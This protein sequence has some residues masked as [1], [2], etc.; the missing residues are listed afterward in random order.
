MHI[1]RSVIVGRDEELAQLAHLLAEARAGRGGAAFLTGEPGIGK[2]R[3][4]VEAADL[5]ATTDMRMLRGRASD[6]G[7]AVPFRPLSEALMSLL[8]GASPPPVEDLGPYRPVLG[9]LVPDWS[10]PGD[11]TDGGSLVVLAEAI[12]RL[13]AILGRGRGCLLVLEDLHDADHETLAVVEYVVDNL[14][15]LPAVLLATLRNGPSGALQL[16]QSAGQRRAGSILELERLTLP[17]VRD[18]IASC[19]EST[20][21][22]VPAPVAEQLW[23]DSGGSPF[24]AEELLHGLVS[25]G[26][27]VP[28]AD[29]WRVTGRIRTEV[30]ASLVRTITDRA[31]RLG[32]QGRQ[33]LSV[34]AVLGHR[35]PLSVVHKVTG[36]SYDALLGQLHAAVAARLVTADEP[37]PDWYAFQ[38]PLTGEALLTRLTPAEQAELSA[39]A[40]DVV[41]TIHPGL[42]GEWCQLVAALRLRAGDR[43]SAARLFADAGRRALAD[44]APGS[45]VTL[46]ERAEQLLGNHE[47]NPLRADVVEALLYAMAEGGEFERAFR[48]ADTLDALG[49]AGLAAPR[50]AALHLRLAWVA[51]SAGRWADGLTQV[52]VA[53][54]LLGEDAADEDTAPLDAVDADLALQAPGARRKQ[55]AEL[56][57]RRAV[58][59]AE[60][61]SLPTVAC[62]AWLVIGAVARERNVAEST[63]CYEKVREIAEEHRLPMW[64]VHG[65]FRAA[66]NAWLAESDTEGLHHAGREARRVG[67]LTLGQNVDATTALHL[68]LCGDFVA[69]VPV[70]DECLA[71][72][73][74]MHLELVGRHL[75]MSRATLAAH[76][77]RRREMEAALLDF[78]RLDGERSQEQPMALGMARA[79]CA[80]LEENRDRARDDI[81]DAL[82]SDDVNPTTFS[83]FGR[84]GLGLLLGVLEGDADWSRYDEFRATAQGAMRWN[85]QFVE[86][87][88]AVLLGRSG[89]TA[90]AEAAVVAAQ[91]SAAPYAMA[92]HLGLRLVAEAAV[93]DGW[94]DPASWLRSAEEYFHNGQVPAV[95]SACRS[96]LRQLGVS[97]QQRRTGTERVPRPLR[98]LGV[99]IREF[100][101]L[102]L[103]IERLDT[104]TI[105]ERL[106]ISPR[107]VEKHVASL[108]IRTDT[109]DRAALARHAGMLLADGNRRVRESG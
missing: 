29:G 49:N 58:D 13:L 87:A 10:A 39:Q 9:R 25:N 12:L 77:G 48:L 59:A 61:A 14:E 41:E 42:P 22:D 18:L 63:A 19:L 45:A 50:R 86:L 74:R 23:A 108:L 70:I 53:R 72:A 11:S 83:L 44:G 84:H 101:V 100:D 99:T 75:L 4:A 2:S 103:L 28:S 38:H 31:D 82:A 36:M 35:F 97:V 79:F 26:Q 37:A 65:L 60:R 47:D 7:P 24:M 109:P 57:A 20:A 92:R 51:N 76:Q 106:H 66:G 94:G 73:T 78:Q 52:A 46:L 32:P 105:A 64:R 43:A 55:E 17:Q 104:K 30:P 16:A 88:Q 15:G 80:L 69:A 93:A 102:Q 95:A 89:R 6:I 98:S 40:A 3:L 71:A 27:L 67:A 90:E 81:A 1:R 68:V 54:K 62:Q 85:R 107:T 56:L 34:A 8:R 33:L 96:L 91:R 5:A 21:D